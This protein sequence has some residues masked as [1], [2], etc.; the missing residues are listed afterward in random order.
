MCKISKNIFEWK[1]ITVDKKNK[2][3]SRPLFKR[4]DEIKKIVYKIINSVEKDGDNA[5]QKYTFELDNIKLSDFFI[6]HDQLISAS[7][8]VSDSFKKAALVSFNNIQKFHSL[9]KIKNIDT[10]T[11]PGIHCQHIATP[12]QSVGLYVPGG[13]TPLVSTALML[14]IPAQL[15]GC[16]DIILCSPPPIKN[17]MLYIAKICGIKKILQLGGA[18]AI[19]ALAFGTKTIKKVDK[20]FGPGNAF[21]T[22]AKIRV[23]DIVPGLS[24]DMPA[25]PSEV[26][27][28]ADSF[29]CPSFI[30]ADLLAQ[31]EHDY[32]S[33]VILLTPCMKIAHEVYLCLNSQIKKL[34]RK[35]YILNS[36]KNSKII[37]TASLEESFNIS[38]QY[39][40]EHLILNIKNARKF[41]NLVKNAGSIFIGPWTPESAGDYITGTNHVLP[42]YGYAKT[43]SGLSVY[44]FQKF[45]TIQEISKNTLKTLSHNI[46]ILSKTEGL[47]AHD[48]AV[49]VR[50][51]SI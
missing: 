50:I 47:D 25:G 5:L 17:E 36:W 31:A 32:N 41:L 45:M 42:T 38:N 34:S 48:Y 2:L 13:I 28:I 44:D 30:A 10:Y 15:A 29:S 33:Q 8:L 26:L 51:K 3:L 27:I 46:S 14:S 49:S 40:P 20:I 24:I 39:A 18:Q 7:S 21:V 35:S 19:A 23:R 4:Q 6:S 22:E 37:I 9:Q 43:Y 12:I 1:N 16:S 11:S